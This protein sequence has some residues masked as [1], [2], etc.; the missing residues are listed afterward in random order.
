M[1][2]SINDAFSVLIIGMITVFFILMLVVIIGNVLVWFTNKYM[3]VLELARPGV[4]KST[5]SDSGSKVAAIVA[6]VDI[7]TN[8]K[9]KVTKI[10]KV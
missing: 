9:G 8:G 1:E 4:T 7:V 3:P 5:K 6:A 2:Q 10:T